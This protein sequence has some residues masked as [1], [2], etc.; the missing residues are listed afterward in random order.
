MVA[1]SQLMSLNVSSLPKK[2]WH[3][4]NHSHVVPFLKNGRGRR[5]RLS[6]GR[7]HAAEADDSRGLVASSGQHAHTV[8]TQ[9]HL[10]DNAETSHLL[11]LDGRSLGLNGRH[12]PHSPT[13]YDLN[14]NLIVNI[15]NEDL[16]L[17]MV[18]CL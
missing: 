5:H 4:G 12:W 15:C 7:L 14:K 9:V 6:G 13:D 3:L 8:S 18:A 1:A 17:M 2:I 16:Y 11:L 10:L